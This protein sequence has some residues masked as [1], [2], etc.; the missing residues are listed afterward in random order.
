[1]TKGTAGNQLLNR[2]PTTRQGKRPIAPTDTAKKNY[3]M[4][5]YGND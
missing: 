2:L 3:T 1:M 5:R 4:I